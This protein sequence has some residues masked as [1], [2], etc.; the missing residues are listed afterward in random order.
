MH[1]RLLLPKMSELQLIMSN[2][3]AAVI[4]IT[5]TWLDDS[6]SDGE[7]R[8]ETTRWFADTEIG[9]AMCLCLY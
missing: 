3:K 1:A 8:I 5:E 6:V 4:S 9:M 7:I 2:S